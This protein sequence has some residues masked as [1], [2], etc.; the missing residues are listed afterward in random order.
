IRGLKGLGAKAKSFGKKVKD[1]AI[2]GVKGVT[3]KVKDRLTRK[4]KP[5]HERDHPDLTAAATAATALL[6]KPE[7]SKGGVAA[8]LPGLKATYGLTAAK[9]VTEPDGEVHITV[10]RASKRTPSQIIQEK[11]SAA[12]IHALIRT[13]ANELMASK[14]VRDRVAQIIRDRKKHLGEPGKDPRPSQGKAAEASAIIHQPR[15]EWTT[16]NITPAKGVTTSDQQTR[17][18]APGHIHVKGLGGKGKYTPDIIAELAAIK[19]RTGA[20]DAQIAKAIREADKGKIPARPLG[21]DKEAVAYLFRLARLEAVESGRS[22]SHLV[23][24]AM[25]HEVAEGKHGGTVEKMVTEHNPMAIGGAG[26]AS[27]RVSKDE[28]VP[29]ASP[30]TTVGSGPKVVEFVRREMA[31]AV[32]YVETLL[33]KKTG[34]SEKELDKLIR[35]ELRDRLEEAARKGSEGPE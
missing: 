27:R 10:Q 30:A 24:S 20:T 18:S 17:T 34:F 12:K 15:P 28:D 33:G 13:I 4:D 2:A 35:N 11:L 3:G 8:A 32:A 19:I 16:E 21:N 26:S 22:P 9:L 14:D 1:R 6:A 23:G 7:S 31:L 25:A 5:G 29:H